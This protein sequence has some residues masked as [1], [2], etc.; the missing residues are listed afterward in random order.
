M[1]TYLT[2]QEVDEKRAI[3]LGAS[4][5]ALGRLFVPAGSDPALFNHWRPAAATRNALVAAPIG[6]SLSDLLARGR[7]AINRAFPRPEWVRIEISNL[8]IHASGHVYIDAIDRDKNAVELSKSRAVMWRAQANK[9][10]K[11]FLDATGRALGKGLKV[12]V[13]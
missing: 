13:L 3:A 11:K 6:I 8:S 1:T 4:V 9:S 12:L 2:I 7:A 10:G 5:D